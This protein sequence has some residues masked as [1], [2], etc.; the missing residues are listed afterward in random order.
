M[1]GR[2]WTRV[3]EYLSNGQLTARWF[4]DEQT[5]EAR[6][7]EGW[8]KP[9][10]WQLGGSAAEFVGAIVARAYHYPPRRPAA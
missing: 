8:H 1:R 10:R 2:R 7:A 6:E 3:A 5:G 9:R 4:Y